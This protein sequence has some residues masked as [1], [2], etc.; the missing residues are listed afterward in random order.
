[1]AYGHKTEHRLRMR[2]KVVL[3]AARGRSN[4]RIA[5]ETGLHPD[6]VRCWRGRFAAHGLGGLSDRERSGRP[7]AF[8]AL[9]VA[10]VKALA[11]RLPAGTGTPLSR[12]SC[13]ELAREAM[14]RGIATFVSVST[15]R[16]WLRDDALKPWQHRSLMSL[17]AEAVL[18][19]PPEQILA[20]GLD[21]SSA[22][23]ADVVRHLC[24]ALRRRNEGL[25]LLISGELGFS[26]DQTLQ[27]TVE[28]IEAQGRHAETRLGQ[29][30]GRQRGEQVVLGR[31]QVGVSDQALNTARTRDRHFLCEL[32]FAAAVWEVGTSQPQTCSH[33]IPVGDH[34]G[35]RHC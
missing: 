32:A 27:G 23:E 11:C 1:M 13:P 24:H 29:H 3:H 19:Q 12:W 9:Q 4:A 5:R 22:S 2:A 33:Q 31:R 10:E 25:R 30:R 28:D 18:G 35:D 7:P 14:A 17:W 6:T 21:K 16:H 8:T 20:R 34:T 26:K 15:V